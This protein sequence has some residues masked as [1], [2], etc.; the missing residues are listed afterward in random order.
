MA[1]AAYKA[2]QVWLRSYLEFTT[3]VCFEIGA[4]RTMRNYGINM[5]E[6][7]HVLR[8][9]TVIHAERGEVGA[10][11]VVIGRNC[12]EEEIE[13]GACIV[14]EMMHVS[15]IYVVRTKLWSGRK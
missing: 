15:V 3:E 7:L 13:V 1:K 2:E 5:S 14:S 11:I 8:T 10:Q 9:G 12:D 6:V 4:Q